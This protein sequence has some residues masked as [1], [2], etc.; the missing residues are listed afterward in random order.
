MYGKRPLS[1]HSADGPRKGP[2]KA[3][4]QGAPHARVWLWVAC[5]L[6]RR[7]IRTTETC[8]LSPNANR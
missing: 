5:G 2:A 1:S 4:D 8:A 3:K 6:W 7:T